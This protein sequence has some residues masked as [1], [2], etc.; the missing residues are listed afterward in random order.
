MDSMLKV[1]LKHQI[2]FLIGDTLTGIKRYMYDTIAEIFKILRR[3]F[4]KIK[5]QWKTIQQ[6]RVE[7]V[8]LLTNA[9]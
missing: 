7:H 6:G 8:R 3:M 4:V 1:T 9:L 5:Q 2:P